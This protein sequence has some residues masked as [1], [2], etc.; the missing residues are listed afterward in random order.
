MN[1]QEFREEDLWTV[2]VNDVFEVNLP[3]LKSVYNRHLEKKQT[4][5]NMETAI[6]MFSEDTGLVTYG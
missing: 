6:K 1:Y 5:L 3:L 2:G 4:M